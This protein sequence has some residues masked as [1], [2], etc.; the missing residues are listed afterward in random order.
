MKLVGAPR[1]P[2]QKTVWAVLADEARQFFVQGGRLPQFAIRVTEPNNPLDAQQ[3]CRAFL[4]SPARRGERLRR[5]AGVLTPLTAIR[6]NDKRHL[7][8]LC[9]PARQTAAAGELR[10][11]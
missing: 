2:R 1:I 6:A 4:F 3:S 5:I 10:V 8:A 7:P 11:I 9:R